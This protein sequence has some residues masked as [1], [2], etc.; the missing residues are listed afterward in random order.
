MQ[1]QESD[2][3]LGSA[4][5]AQQLQQQL[6]AAGVQAERLL[7]HGDLLLGGGGL[8]AAAGW[9]Q[10]QRLVLGGGGGVRGV[11]RGGR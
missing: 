10:P 7:Q 3:P 5:R 4:Y 9:A 2:C 6:V 11:E 8:A 1:Q